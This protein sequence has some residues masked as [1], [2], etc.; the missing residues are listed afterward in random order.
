[1][2]QKSYKINV[3]PVY[4][5]EFLGIGQIVDSNGQ[6]DV[7]QRVCGGVKETRTESDGL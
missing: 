1:M 6:E 7:E 2:F 5:C 4:L 3:F